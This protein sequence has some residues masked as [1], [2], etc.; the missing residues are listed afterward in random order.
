MCFN[1]NKVDVELG[2]SNYVTQSDLK[3]EIGVDT[4]GFSMSFCWRY[5]T[6]LFY[7]S[8]TSSIFSNV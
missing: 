2:L 6:K 3:S 4:S 8:G 7:I 1:K 5:V